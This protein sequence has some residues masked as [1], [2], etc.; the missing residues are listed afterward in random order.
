MKVRCINSANKPTRIPDNEWIEKGK[1]YTVINAVPIQ[2]QAGKLGYELAEITLSEKSFPYQ[3][4]DSDRFTIC[5][6]G[7]V[8]ETE[9]SEVLEE[10]EL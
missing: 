9:E 4:Y 1:E 2:L 6:D 8:H 3:Y 10:F 5:I 7:V